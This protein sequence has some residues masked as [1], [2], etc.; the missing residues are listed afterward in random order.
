MIVNFPVSIGLLGSLKPFITELG[1]HT[2]LIEW[3]IRN[4]IQRLSF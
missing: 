4:H 3:S 1:A 2:V